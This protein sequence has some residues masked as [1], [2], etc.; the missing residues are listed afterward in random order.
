MDDFFGISLDA[1]SIA[2]QC[3]PRTFKQTV[4]AVLAMKRLHGPS[5]C[6]PADPSRTQYRPKAADNC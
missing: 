2:F 1:S 5:T 6:F 3:G 4:Q